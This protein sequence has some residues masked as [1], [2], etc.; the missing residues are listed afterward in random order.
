MRYLSAALV[1]FIDLFMA[2][3]D[4]CLDEVLAAKRADIPLVC[5]I[6]QERIQSIYQTTST[7]AAAAYGVVTN[8]LEAEKVKRAAISARRNSIDGRGVQESEPVGRVFK[9]I[10]QNL[11]AP[12]G[13]HSESFSGS[14]NATPTVYSSPQDGTLS[15]EP[16]SIVNTAEDPIPVQVPAAKRQH[17]QVKRVSGIV[18]D[19]RSAKVPK[20][21][22]TDTRLPSLSASTV[23]SDG[24]TRPAS[25]PLSQQPPVFA[26]PAPYL[27][28][29]SSGP[30]VDYQAG[31]NS[32]ASWQSDE[33]L[34][35]SS[36]LQTQRHESF[37]YPSAGTASN[38]LDSGYGQMFAQQSQPPITW[39]TSGLFHPDPSVLMHSIGFSTP[40]TPHHQGEAVF[41]SLGMSKLQTTLVG[42]QKFGHTE[43]TSSAPLHDHVDSRQPLRAPHHSSHGKP[44]AGPGT[45]QPWFQDV[46]SYQ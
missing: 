34:D 23:V 22:P 21:S 32:Y 15:T 46:I 28:N 43:S 45:A 10:A 17:K 36:L 9:R 18:D 19:E 3:D 39:D 38:S 44:L 37:S 14:S 7:F 33:Y 41:N 4:G 24:F 27:P 40:S 2:M 1:I 30:N 11:S 26:S 25:T 16:K 29:L 8:L 35:D 6:L 13:V 5:S 12:S 31:M 20:R 42:G